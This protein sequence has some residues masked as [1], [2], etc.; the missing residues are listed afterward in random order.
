MDFSAYE[1]NNSTNRVFKSEVPQ[2]CKDEP[3]LFG[4]DEAGRGPVLGKLVLRLVVTATL[5]NSEA[6]HHCP[7]KNDVN[8]G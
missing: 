8:A 6:V 2:I 4:I 5:P 3:C 1:D 7:Y